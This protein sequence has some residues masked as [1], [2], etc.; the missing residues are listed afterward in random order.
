MEVLLGAVLWYSRPPPAAPWWLTGSRL[1]P[2]LPTSPAPTAPSG[3]LP[4]FYSW[5]RHRG[6]S[7]CLL[8]ITAASRNQT[9]TTCFM[10]DSSHWAAF[11]VWPA[12]REPSNIDHKNSITVVRF[13]NWLA[14]W[15]QFT[16]LPLNKPRQNVGPPKTLSCT[17]SFLISDDIAKATVFLNVSSGHI[18]LT[19]SSSLTCLI[20]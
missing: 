1:L 18:L 12:C 7:A 2:R 9:T 16:S 4:I 19:V 3:D 15:N 14:G 20:S 10:R 11:E 8:L 17:L 13:Q 6:R 5:Q